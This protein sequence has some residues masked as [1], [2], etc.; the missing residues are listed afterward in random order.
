M[1]LNI[2]TLT[3]AV[4]IIEDRSEPYSEEYCDAF[5][6]LIDTGYVFVLQGWY[7]RRAEEMIREGFCW[8][9]FKTVH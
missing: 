7:Q 6:Y 4:Q 9:P 5:Q 2:T 1:Q 3:Q 8:A